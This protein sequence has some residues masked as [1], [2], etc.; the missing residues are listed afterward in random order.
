M[1]IKEIKKTENYDEWVSY[2]EDRPF[3]D[4]SY[5]ISNDKLKQLG[6]EIKTEFNEGLNELL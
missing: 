1:L 5:Y 4:K 3:N 6:W 2:V